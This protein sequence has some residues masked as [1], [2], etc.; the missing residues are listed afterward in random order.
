MTHFPDSI[1]FRH[2]WRE[3]Q[4][5]VLNDL[6]SHLS[7][8]KLHVIAPPGSGK[9]ILGLEVIRQINQP[10]LILSPS[11]AIRNQWMS[12]FTADFAAAL[13]PPELNA[14]ISTNIYEPKFLT[15]ITYQALHS[16]LSETEDIPE[17]DEE[18]SIETFSKCSSE[19][20]IAKYKAIGLQVLA[21]DEC[22]HL[23]NEWW[24]SITKLTTHFPTLTVISLTATPPYDVSSSE[25]ERYQDFC[26]PVDTEI[27]VPELIRKGDLCAHHDFVYL[28]NPRENENQIIVEF[29]QAV[30]RCV[31]SIISNLEFHELMINHPF[32][33]N[34]E[35]QME[36]ILENPSYFASILVFLTHIKTPIEKTFF[37]LLG[38]KEKQTPILNDEWLEIL[39]T[40]VFFL[41]DT[42]FKDNRSVL[43]PIL[44]T[45][46][47]AGAVDRKRI[48]LITTNKISKILSQSSSK[49][50]SI[51]K[52]VEIEKDALGD[53]LRL[54]ILTDYIRKN[55][56]I[57]TVT[58]IK[59]VGVLPIFESVRE[60][61]GNSLQLG[62]LSGTLVIIPTAAWDQFEQ[63][64]H[65]QQV[66]S[67]KINS[68]PY[69]PDSRY[70]QISMSGDSKKKM[71]HI[72]TALFE[73]GMIHVLVGTKAL[74]GE[75]WD[76]PAINSL[77]LASFVGSFVQSNQ[78]RGRAIRSNGSSSKVSNIWHLAC[79][80]PY[81]TNGGDDILLCRRRFTAFTG[82]SNSDNTITSGFNR[83]K[84]NLTHCDSSAVNENN[85]L[86][87]ELAKNREQTLQ[88][89]RSNLSNGDSLDDL[90]KTSREAKTKGVLFTKTVYAILLQ[91]ISA[92][93]II[94][95]RFIGETA[96]KFDNFGQSIIWGFLIACV[97]TSIKSGMFLIRLLRTG[98][99]ESSISFISRA[100]LETLIELKL[101]QTDRKSLQLITEKIADGSLCFFLEGA[102]FYESTLFRTALQEILDPIDNPRYL[103]IRSSKFHEISQQDFHA[104]PTIFGKKKE[105]VELFEKYWTKHVGNCSIQYTRTPEGRTSLLKGRSFALSAQTEGRS[106]VI[107]KW[108]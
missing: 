53:S 71:V 86:M 6:K 100:L 68:S 93:G 16:A 31:A 37:E 39:L 70:I 18:E 30:A 13:T 42:Y 48:T 3:Y 10:T 72:V 102:S 106:E 34:R 41:D 74:L 12:R 28:S 35:A 63:I 24:K 94:F 19:E 80:D 50:N 32:I 92:G 103:L 96:T 101:I 15:V 26:G 97:L 87:A 82:I 59:K 104:V 66:S 84:I 88:K 47:K 58:E 56:D 98:P 78:M 65:S 85:Q 29:H 7:D 90:L 57:S 79:I 1:K 20:V 60:Q 38:T 45:L 46:R 14:L 54:V 61:F 95:A 23:K 52:I 25:W 67:E 73:A 8:N 4:Q 11:I 33:Q 69:Q 49:I 62:V 27:T 51:L 64:A 89:W 99:I 83:L 107:S 5:R 91:A 55:E 2:S 75:G 44:D 9:T 17:D 81:S 108:R 36:L 77:I 40:G 76:S 43:D 21:A 22:H 105:H